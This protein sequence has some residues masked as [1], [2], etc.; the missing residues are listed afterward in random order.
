MCKDKI[1]FITPIQKY[2]N[3]EQI[4]VNSKEKKKRKKSK[5]MT[6]RSYDSKIIEN[7]DL[8]GTILE[9]LARILF[10]DLTGDH[11]LLHEIFTLW[12]K[13]EFNAR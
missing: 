5:S 10:D 8:R 9:H 2:R 3:D 1:N 13:F 7:N 4:G 11:S 12:E 6:I